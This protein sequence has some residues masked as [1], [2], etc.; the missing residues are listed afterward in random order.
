MHGIGEFAQI[1]KVSV[2]TLRH[3]DDLALLEPAHVDASSGYRSYASAQLTDLHR[4][5]ALKD[6]GLTLSEIRSAQEQPAE[7]I[8][9]RLHTR[10]AELERSVEEEQQRVERLRARL[11][12]MT[13]DHPMSNITDP[14]HDADVVIKPLDGH[15][16]AVAAETVVDFEADFA[17]I[18]ARL[19]PTI[20]EELGRLGI[21]P[22][23]STIA[24]YNALPDGQLLI[25]AG[26]PVAADVVEIDSELI[27]LLELPTAE[28]GATLVH[29]G[30]MATIDRSYAALDGWI[31]DAGETA[32]G[33]SREIYHACPPDQADWV[34]E[35]QF[36]LE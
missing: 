29:R 33:Y 36:V 16:V 20:F 35:L 12:L 13:G 2:R 17:P 31:Q 30:E 11:N 34:T 23:G 4:I 14:V 8:I 9:D 18:F 10:L 5:L 1:A 3:Y 21:A 26:V 25:S 32:A 6:A 19:Y 15:H 24:F 22:A 28:R 27:E 7:A